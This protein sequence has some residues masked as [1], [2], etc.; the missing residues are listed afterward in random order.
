[1]SIHPALLMASSRVSKRLCAK[2]RLGTAPRP[3]RSSGTK[4]KPRLRRCAGPCEPI[5]C[6]CKQMLSSGARVSSPLKAY[7][8]SRCPLPDTPAMP[9]IS[10]WRTSKSMGC[11]FMPKGSRRGKLSCLTAKTTSP[12]WLLWCTKAEGSLPIIIWLSEA[13]VSCA[14]MHSP[15]TRPLR[16]TVQWVHKAR[17]SCSLWLMYKILQPST[18]NWRSTTNSLSTAWGVST[19][20]GS[21]NISNR[22]S[23]NKARMISTRCI[24][25]TLKVCTGRSGSTSRP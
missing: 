19:E 25:P 20:V 2:L 1:M 6:P 12:G 18:T 13:L 14:G 15:L 5:G 22:G 10:P 11:K 24:S 21:S 8:S 4:C 16:K 3:K 7:S 9:T 23:D 17:I